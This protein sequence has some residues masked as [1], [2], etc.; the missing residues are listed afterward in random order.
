[1]SNLE[2]K[3]NM[4]VQFITLEKWKQRKCE[5]TIYYIRKEE[6]KE[7]MKI[8]FIISKIQWRHKQYSECNDVA[9]RL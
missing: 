7:N 9:R 6:N 4:E 2:N 8:Q 1:M 3:E 5:S